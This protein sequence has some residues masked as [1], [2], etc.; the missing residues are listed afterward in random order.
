MLSFIEEFVLC[1]RKL[2]HWEVLLKVDGW[3][4]EYVSV[5]NLLKH[6]KRKTKSEG[7][8]ATYL[9]TLAQFVKFCGVSPDDLASLD[10]EE[11]EKK[12]QE[13]CDRAKAPRTANRKMEELK[14]FFKCNGFRVGSKCNLN[15]ERHYVSARQ[16][17]RAEYIPTDEEIDR[18]LNKAGLNLKWRA[19]FLALYTSGL[20][21]STLRALRYGDI[22]EELEGGIAPLLVKVYP[23]MKE[24]VPEACKGRLPYFTF[25]SREAVEAVRAYLSERENKLG[26]LEDEQVLFCS[27]DKRIAREK[28][29]YTPLNMTA[30]EKMLKKAAKAALIKEWQYVTPHCLRKAFERAVRNAGLSLKDQEFLMGHILPGSQDTYYDKTKVED[31]RE[32]Y[33]KITFFSYRTANAE[34]LRKKQILDMVKLLGFPEEKIKKVYEALAKY[35]R[36][37]EAIEK[38]KKLTLESRRYKNS[39]ETNYSSDWKERKN[40][41]KRSIRIVQGD[42]K[43]IRFLDEGWDLVKEL[44]NDRFLLKRNFD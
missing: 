1:A 41:V 4:S 19:F 23:S 21:N 12:V 43:L 34:E 44:S 3:R 26:P 15:L 18:I 28:R 32:K 13:F 30:P 14:T 35:E 40:R 42:R 29:P 2:R 33:A 27:D 25:M 5:E 37:D 8:R 11:V 6:L 10:K 16:R 24:V 36:V 7:S 39:S 31:M 38:I 17:S 9:K 20:R 22:Q